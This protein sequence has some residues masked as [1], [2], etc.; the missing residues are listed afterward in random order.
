[1]TWPAFARRIRV[2]LGFAF[3]VVYLWLARPSWWSLAAGA[4][5]AAAGLWLRALA[6]GHVR[7]SAEITTSG[8]YA[9][10][11]N[12]LYLG[13][14]VIATGFGLASRN[15]WVALLIVFFFVLI[16]YPVI[17]WEEKYLQANFP[18]FAAYSA[19]VPRFF[20]RWQ[21]GTNSGVFSPELY[22]KYRE[23]NALIGSAAMLLALV[24]KLLWWGR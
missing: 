15:P 9:H 23:Y 18:E 1:M 7:K 12:P 5:I 16:Y 8:P 19:S 14:L 22:M 21:T 6:A 13:S 24:I 11:R 17:Y 20:P 2:P 10:T 3:A 4:A